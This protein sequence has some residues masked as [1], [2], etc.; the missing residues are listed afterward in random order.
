MPDGTAR[1][2]AI[3][4]AEELARL[5]Q[6]CLRN[7]RQSVLEQWG[8]PSEAAAMDRELVLGLES[9]AADGV[10]GAAR[11]AAGAGVHGSAAPAGP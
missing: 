5:P 10:A 7:D 6:T 4:L 8:A 3:A 1:A 2:A 9:L 11:F